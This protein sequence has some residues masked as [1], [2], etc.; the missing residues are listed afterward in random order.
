MEM[1]HLR[2][3]ILHLL[4]H[5]GKHL[6]ELVAVERRLGFGGLHLE[7]RCNIRIR[8]LCVKDLDV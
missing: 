3:L 5:G 4:S 7:W 8:V 6:E 2:L 1:D